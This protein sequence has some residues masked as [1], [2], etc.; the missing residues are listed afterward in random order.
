VRYG[1]YHG[2]MA[3]VLGRNIMFGYERL[4]MSVDDMIRGHIDLGCSRGESLSTYRA[5]SL[6]DFLMLRRGIV[7]LTLDYM[8][9]LLQEILTILFG[10]YVR[11]GVDSSLF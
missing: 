3:S 5:A 9:I 11:I 1:V 10:L 6:I 8:L 2:H 7:I 4:S